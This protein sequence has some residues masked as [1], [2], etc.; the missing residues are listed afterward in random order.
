MMKDS[1]SMGIKT[2]S[3]DFVSGPVPAQ[4]GYCVPSVD[5]QSQLIR[6]PYHFCFTLK[7]T[8]EAF[9]PN[10]ELDRLEMCH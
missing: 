5:T 8:C 2:A 10:C 1:L 6:T 7:W 3:W 4:W 9:K